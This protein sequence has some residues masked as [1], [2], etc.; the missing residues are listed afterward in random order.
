M[1]NCVL[2]ML[3]C[4]ILNIMLAIGNPTKSKLR[5]NRNVTM[6][7]TKCRGPD[8]EAMVTSTTN[9]NNVEFMHKDD[10]TLSFGVDYN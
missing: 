1:L 8:V 9:S 5:V 10:L 6:F 2:I 7:W 4:Y 3:L